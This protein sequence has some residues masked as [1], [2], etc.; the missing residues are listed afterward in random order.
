M[1]VSEKDQ[2]TSPRRLTG[3]AVWLVVY[4]VALALVA[5]WPVPV[6]SG[7][8]VFLK[9]VT[10]AVPWLTYPRIE[11]GANILLFVPLGLL[12]A[13]L[14]GRSRHLVL[15]IAITITVTIESLQAVLL[16]RRT[17]SLLDVVANTAGA[18]VG[19][20]IVAG[21]EAARRRADGSSSAG[22]GG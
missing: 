4:G 19:L 20:L 10:R 9:A 2:R 12:L 3:P 14:L 18:C 6:D 17:A 21:F 1:R 5:L 7:S 11:F 13:L 15:P 22:G 16:T 8:R